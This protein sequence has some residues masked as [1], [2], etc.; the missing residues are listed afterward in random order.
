VR[1]RKR[2]G[3]KIMKRFWK[4]EGGGFGDM[5]YFVEIFGAFSLLPY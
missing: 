5:R 4:F 3:K 1:E 2:W